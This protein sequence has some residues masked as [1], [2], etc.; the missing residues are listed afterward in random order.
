VF[1]AA[2]GSDRFWW[3]GETNNSAH[4]HVFDEQFR[5]RLQNVFTFLKCP[6]PDELDKSVYQLAARRG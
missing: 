5:L 4:D 1:Y 2:E 6:Y 3:F